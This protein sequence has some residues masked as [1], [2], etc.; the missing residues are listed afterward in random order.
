MK[1]Q[2]EPEQISEVKDETAT[3]DPLGPELRK[4][5]KVFVANFP[6]T[7]KSMKAFIMMAV[8]RELD[9]YDDLGRKRQ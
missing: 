3:Y 7:A 6:E 8:Q 5:V 1:P 2:V 4:R 9:S